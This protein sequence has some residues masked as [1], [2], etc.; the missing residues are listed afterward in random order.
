MRNINRNLFQV[1]ASA[2]A[3]EEYDSDAAELVRAAA[4]HLYKARR[5]HD[6]AALDEA[7]NLTIH[8]AAHLLNQ[9][10]GSVYVRFPIML[11]ARLV[12]L[13]AALLATTA[14]E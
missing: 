14:N 7:S 8:A 1:P 13:E 3:L 12:E 10:G 5:D 9:A 2:D 4:Q 6:Q 11:T